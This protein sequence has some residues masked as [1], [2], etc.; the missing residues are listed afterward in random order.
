[1]ILIVVLSTSDAEADR[2]QAYRLHANSYL[3]KPL[4]GGYFKRMIQ[5]VS[6]YWGTWNR[7]PQLAQTNSRS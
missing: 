5:D 4:N 2:L 3:V 1:M 6:L 7:A